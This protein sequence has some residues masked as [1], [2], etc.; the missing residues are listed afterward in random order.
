M[1]MCC[2]TSVN[3][4]KRIGVRHGSGF[5]GHTGKINSVAISSDNKFII[6]GSEDATI[7]IW[8][9]AS[10]KLGYPLH[11]MYRTNVLEGHTKGVRSVALSKN[12]QFIVSGSWDK[13]VRLWDRVTGESIKTFCGHSYFVNS[14]DISPNNKYIVSSGRKDKT[15]RIWDVETGECSNVLDIG[16]DV[17]SVCFSNDNQFVLTEDYSNNIKLWEVET[18]NCTTEIIYANAIS[19]D[20][21]FIVREQDKTLQLVDVE[22]HEIIKEFEGHTTCLA[23]FA[24]SNNDQW[25]VSGA[26]LGDDFVRL[27]N[28]ETGEQTRLKS[29]GDLIQNIDSVVISADNKYIVSGACGWGICLW[30]VESITS[31]HVDTAN[32]LQ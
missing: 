8:D 12:D 25:I 5:N 18:G 4:E 24:L 31:K 6:S 11:S 17:R 21:K 3:I 28:V 7:R 23:S 30:N 29:G 19:S 26:G 32:P 14:V 1:G 13:T 16:N 22:T 9:V 15:A 27:W 20:G 2:S 10:G